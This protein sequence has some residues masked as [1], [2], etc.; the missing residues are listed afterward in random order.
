VTCAIPGSSSP[1]HMA[2]N[3][4]AGM[5]VQPEEAWWDDKLDAFRV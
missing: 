1:E 2:Q 5:G 4:M 3:A